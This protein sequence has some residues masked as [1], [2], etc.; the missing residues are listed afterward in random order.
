[1]HKAKESFAHG[2]AEHVSG[3]HQMA[4]GGGS[5][6]DLTVHAKLGRTCV[7]QAQTYSRPSQTGCICSWAILNTWMLSASRYAAASRTSTINDLAIFHH[8]TAFWWIFPIV[9]CGRSLICKTAQQLLP[10][11]RAERS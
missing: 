11:E 9:G 6:P 7:R 1:M 2:M 8:R 10:G 5:A 4:L 3:H